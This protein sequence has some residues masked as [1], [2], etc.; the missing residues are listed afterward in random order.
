MGRLQ[1]TTLGTMTI[2]ISE[3]D[4]TSTAITLGQPNLRGLSIFAPAALT[5][6]CKVKVSGDGGT[7]YQYLQSGGADVEVGAGDCV[8]IDYAGFDSILIHSASAEA[9]DRSFVLKGVEETR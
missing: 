4:Q 3:D 8:V 2:D 1:A 7:T 6:L 5:G 9:A